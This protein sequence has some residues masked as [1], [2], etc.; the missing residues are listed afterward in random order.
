V[1]PPTA[2]RPRVVVVRLVD[3]VDALL[4]RERLTVYPIVV[5]A[6]FV[7]V[8]A[9]SLRVTTALPDF[10]ARWTAG[11]MLLDGQ[12]SVLYDPAAQSGL[13]AAM[14]AD[15]LSWFVSP[16][17]VA[18]LCAPFGAL[19]YPVAAAIWTALNLG[20]LA[21][22]ARMLSRI[23][24]RLAPLGTTFGMVLAASCQPVLELVGAGQDTAMVLAALAAAAAL[25]RTGRGTAAGAAL[26]VGIVKPHL[27]VLVPI[28]LALAS[29]WR[30]VA[31]FLAASAVVG[32]ATTLTFGWGVWWSWRDALVSPLYLT[33]VGQGQAWK[34]VSVNGLTHSLLAP[35]STGVATAVWL[36]IAVVVLGVTARAVHWRATPAWLLLLL[37]VPLTTVLTSPHVM[38]YDLVIVL[39]GALLVIRSGDGG[40]RVVAALAYVLL[41][42]APLL[43]LVAQGVP[44]IAAL[45][46]PWVCLAL[47]WMWWRAVRGPAIQGLRGAAPIP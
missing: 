39:P 16:P 23:D 5:I 38:V 1:R 26:A 9:I 35:L 22:S 46:A 42:V 13:Q 17:Y 4:T 7:V 18:L 15:R 6:L 32:M 44:A 45:G 19:P 28:V 34:N 31:S 36:V 29:A 20:L 2:I 3:R 43:H 40:D 25:L 21:L 8:W 30:A 47:A 11:R 24:P 27:M 14:G 10:L 41:F 12:L 37:V 33:E